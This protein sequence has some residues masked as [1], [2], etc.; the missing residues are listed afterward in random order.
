MIIK[1]ID[2]FLFGPKFWNVLTEALKIT[3]LHKND[4]NQKHGMV[5]LESLVYLLPCSICRNSY[6]E[7]YYQVKQIIRK[8]SNLTQLLYSLHHSVNKKLGM[9]RDYSNLPSVKEPTVLTR[10]KF[11]KRLSTWG[12]FASEEDVWDMLFISAIVYPEPESEES[13]KEKM[14][15]EL[16]QQHYY[17][18]IHSL[19]SLLIQGVSHYMVAY[20]LQTF[21]QMD[22]K[23]FTC[24]KD[25]LKWLYQ[26]YTFWVQWKIDSIR[27][28]NPNFS[29]PIPSFEKLK[30]HYESWKP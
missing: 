7:F 11:Q 5:L 14:H 6:L 21:S 9:Q 26:A 25:L 2:A 4:Q 22:K 23:F 15:R 8:D 10:E 20:S 1:N 17:F 19:S 28:Q 3:T 13:E 12:T 30:S 16:K 29:I 27:L 18:F 24:K